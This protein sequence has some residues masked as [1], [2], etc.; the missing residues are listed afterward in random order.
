LAVIW[1]LILIFLA[2]PAIAEY[3]ILSYDGKKV[4]F[5][6]EDHETKKREEL[7]INVLDFMGRLIMHIPRKR[8]YQ[9]LLLMNLQYGKRRSQ[10]KCQDLYAQNVTEK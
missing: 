8:A 2:R 9:G 1:N 6:Y 7:E 5:W 4:R 3:R 10:E